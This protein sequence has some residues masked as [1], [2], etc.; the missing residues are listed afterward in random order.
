MVSSSLLAE[1]GAGILF[2]ENMIFETLVKTVVRGGI[3][4][5]NIVCPKRAFYFLYIYLFLILYSFIFL[6]P[7][8]LFLCS[9]FQYYI[10]IYSFFLYSFSNIL[11]CIPLSSQIH[12]QLEDD[13]AFQSH[14]FYIFSAMVSGQLHYFKRSF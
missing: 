10:F 14:G 2:C 11:F 7:F 3:N 12:K 6:F 1:R 5:I 8:L 13:F 4:I 9:T